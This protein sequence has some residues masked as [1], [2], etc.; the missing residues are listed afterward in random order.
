MVARGKGI[1]Q[2]FD[3]K[4]DVLGFRQFGELEV[5]Q[6]IGLWSWSERIFGVY[7]SGSLAEFSVKDEEISLVRIEA[8]GLNNLS[9]FVAYQD[10]FAVGGKGVLPAVFQ[11]GETVQKVLSAKIPKPDKLGLPVKVDIKSLAFNSQGHLCCGTAKGSIWVYDFVGKDYHEIPAFKDNSVTGIWSNGS[12]LLLAGTKGN[13]ELFN[14]PKALGGYG[15]AAAPSGTIIDVVIGNRW[16]ISA[17]LDRFIRVYEKESRKLVG[18]VFLGHV[19]VA[20]GLARVDQLVKG[21]GDDLWEQ[22][23]PVKDRK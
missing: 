6:C 2:Y 22:L 7:S 9:A 11:L 3:H 14:G 4:G 15:T 13:L 16:I 17:S 20:L 21:S 12:N 10:K 23:V 18:K 1:V 8:L 5:G 19:P